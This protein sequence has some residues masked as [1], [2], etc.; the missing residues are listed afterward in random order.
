MIATVVFVLH[1]LAAYTSA[2]VT[3]THPW[4]MSAR[5]SDDVMIT[6]LTKHDSGSLYVCMYTCV[7]LSMFMKMFV[8]LA[9]AQSIIVS[10]EVSVSKI[11]SLL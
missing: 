2:I 6:S 3:L 7:V 9:Y 10:Y 11:N 8:C 5:I 1:Q 4:R